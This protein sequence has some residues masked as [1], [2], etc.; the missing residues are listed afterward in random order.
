MSC[1]YL[2]CQSSNLIIH[3]EGNLVKLYICKLVL[4]GATCLECCK[5]Q[6]AS[7]VHCSPQ[8]DSYGKDSKTIVICEIESL[9]G[10][11]IICH[12]DGLRAQH[13]FNVVRGKNVNYQK[14]DLLAL[15]IRQ[16]LFDSTGGTFSFVQMQSLLDT[17]V[18]ASKLQKKHDLLSRKIPSCFTPINNQ[19]FL[20]T[21]LKMLGIIPKDYTLF[22][23]KVKIILLLNKYLVTYGLCAYY[24]LKTDKYFK[25]KYNFDNKL[26]LFACDYPN[27]SLLNNLQLTI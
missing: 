14:S 12:S 24:I 5:L 25:S 6:D 8:D 19:F 3:S 11:H 7:F 1:Q 18:R 16:S 15:C 2:S 23:K 22:E 13:L 21:A 9:I 4:S 17:T 26:L 27:L 20:S 10:R